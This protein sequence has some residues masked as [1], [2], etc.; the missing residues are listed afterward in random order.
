[1]ALAAAKAIGPRVKALCRLKLWR[2]AGTA[3]KYG[4]L[5]DAF[6]RHSYLFGLVQ[7]FM[8]NVT[9]SAF[10]IFLTSVHGRMRMIRNCLRWLVLNTGASM[11]QTFKPVS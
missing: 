2:A 10:N 8:S 7:Y 5:Y 3:E 6:K 1:M 9:L 4:L 11:V